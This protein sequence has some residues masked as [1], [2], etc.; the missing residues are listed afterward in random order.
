MPVTGAAGSSFSA[1]G[2]KVCRQ[3]EAWWLRIAR[4]NGRQGLQHTAGDVHKFRP[5][6]MFASGR[7]GQRPLNQ[8]ALH[9]A[10]W[11]LN[12]RITPGLPDLSQ[13]IVIADAFKH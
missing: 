1:A 5:G 10:P 3:S 8:L 12:A 7:S 2:L 4:G 13:E 9:L 6:L 11:N